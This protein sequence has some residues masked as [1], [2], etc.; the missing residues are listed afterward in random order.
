MP[1][2]DGLLLA[3]GYSSRMGE[4]KPLMDH[5]GLPFVVGIARKTS[6]VCRRV[7]VVLGHRGDDIRNA[8]DSHTP[9][10]SL[11]FVENPR[12]DQGMFT[13]LQAGLA[14]LADAEWALYHFADQP[15]L[16][17][18]FYSDFVPCA[19]VEFDCIQP[20]HQSHKGHPLLL[21]RSLFAAVQSAPPSGTLRDVIR[22]SNA[23][24]KLWECRFPQILQD[25]NTPADLN[26][27]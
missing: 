10:A 9:I 25:F 20:V 6:R 15:H 7:I 11:S 19:Q 8:F 16:P 24:V 18:E 4:F 22:D 1:V 23:R 17:E 26:R 2:I 5:D 3:A 27:S 14:A 12:F 21:R 13:S